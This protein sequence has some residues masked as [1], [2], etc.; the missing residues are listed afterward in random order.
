MADEP[1]H[2]SKGF[3]VVDGGW[4]AVEAK[5]GRERRLEARL[6]LFAFERFEQR[7]FFAADVGA[8]AVVRVQLKAEIGA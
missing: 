3:G 2:G 1:R 4:L 5:T 6:A 7:R 8:K